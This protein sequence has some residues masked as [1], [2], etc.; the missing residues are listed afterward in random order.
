MRT[1]AAFQRQIDELCARTTD[2]ALSAA[3]IE[4][5]R[6]TIASAR[7]NGQ[8]PEVTSLVSRSAERFL[9]VLNAADEM[10]PADD[11][12]ELENYVQTCLGRPA[13]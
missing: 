10:L 12:L 7:R 9:R 5:L 6:A 13:A 8:K 1:P 11:V 4:S 2:V 3:D